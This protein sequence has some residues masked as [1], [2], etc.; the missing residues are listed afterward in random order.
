MKKILILSIL[1]IMGNII[2]K[3]EVMNINRV[4]HASFPLMKPFIIEDT[5]VN[6]KSF[7]SRSLLDAATSFEILKDAP[8]INLQDIAAAQKESG[9][10]R[11]TLGLISFSIQNE[12]YAT[13]KLK[14]E[15]LQNYTALLD[16]NKIGTEEFALEP[17]VHT[18]NI[19]YILD[20]DSNQQPL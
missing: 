12:R 17:S 11:Y 1:L 18:I 15:G 8:Y 6:S 19:K 16:G 14:I 7:N 20:P 10:G 4:K 5:D 3:A 9:N 2:L 13:A